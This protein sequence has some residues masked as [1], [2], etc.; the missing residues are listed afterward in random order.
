MASQSTVGTLKMGV[1]GV[2]PAGSNLV[3]GQNDGNTASLDLNGF[4]QTA[5]S[6]V[7]NPT[8]PNA[9]TVGKSI[10]CATPATLTINQATTT[11]YASLI[12]GEVSFEKSGTGKLTLLGANTHNGLTTVSNGVLNIQHRTALGS[13]TGGTSVANG[14]T[15]EVQ[16]NLVIGAEPLSLNG[17][18]AGGGALVNVSGTNT[19]GGLITVATNSTISALSGSTLNLI[20][21]VDK[22]ATTATFTGGGTINI[23]GVPVSGS[24]PGSD[25]VIDG[26]G[27]NMNVASTY[28]GPTFIKGGGLL[29]NGANQA[30]P[31][32]SK[33]TLGDATSNSDGTWFLSGTTQTIAGLASAGTGAKSIAL[34]GGALS[35]NQAN[36]SVYKGAI[37]GVGSVEKTG[38]GKLALL[39][40]GG[41]LDFPTLTVSGGKLD[42][43]SALGTGTTTVNATAEINIGVSETL[44]ALNIGNGGGVNVGALPPPAPAQASEPF[45][46]ALEIGSATQAVPEPGSAALLL[47]GLATLLGFRRRR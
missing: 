29:I 26:V 31:N 35:V 3:L 21:G 38:A 10:T 15:L 11:T 37:T 47:G 43:H 39:A 34:G 36:D 22:T 42:L 46:P 2:L 5:A 40:A 6:L 20:G 41:T 32:V 9:N 27:L 30:V 8:T 45:A 7:S 1:A 28:N 18:G 33:V 44:A 24:L 14:A 23:N 13:V 16:G 19:Y 12:T 4:N 25:L 17:A